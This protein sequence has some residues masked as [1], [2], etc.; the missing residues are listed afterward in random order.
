MYTYSFLKSVVKAKSVALLIFPITMTIK[1]IVKAEPYN[2]ETR[3]F[4]SFSLVVIIQEIIWARERVMTVERAKY[5]ASYSMLF[6]ILT[7]FKDYLKHVNSH[8]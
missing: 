7:M 1:R 3:A 4:L 2:R 5:A 6:P 8:S